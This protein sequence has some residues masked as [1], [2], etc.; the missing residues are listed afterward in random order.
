M[1]ISDLKKENP[2]LYKELSDAFEKEVKAKQGL[3]GCWSSS[4]IEEMH[5]IFD[6]PS[7]RGGSVNKV[8]RTIVKE[9]DI[10]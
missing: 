3:E 7:F 4:R 1:T 6:K 2:A 5:R 8:L 9:L 10:G